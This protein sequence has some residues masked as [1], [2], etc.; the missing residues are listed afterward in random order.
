MKK[1]DVSFVAGDRMSHLYDDLIDDMI[2]NT[3]I[4]NI[5]KKSLYRNS[6]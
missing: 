4:M 5:L 1:L 3:W 2:C 6:S